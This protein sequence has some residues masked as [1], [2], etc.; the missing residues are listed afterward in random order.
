MLL[1]KIDEES[2]NTERIN[3]ILFDIPHDDGLIGDCIWVFGSKT[4]CDEKNC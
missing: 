3:Q 1:S 2:L 4:F